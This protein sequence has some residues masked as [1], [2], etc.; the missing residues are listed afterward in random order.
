MRRSGFKE[1]LMGLITHW[2]QLLQ[3]SI[4]INGT[5]SKKVF[6]QGRGSG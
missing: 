6:S 5:V 1:L 4:I 2:F 3:K